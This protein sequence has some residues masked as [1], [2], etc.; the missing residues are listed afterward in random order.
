MNAANQPHVFSLDYE[1][2]LR[3]A[4]VFEDFRTATRQSLARDVEV[5][6]TFQIPVLILA[7]T[8]DRPLS[9]SLRERLKSM[10]LA[11]PR[12][13]RGDLDDMRLFFW[14]GGLRNDP[15]R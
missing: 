3:A 11:L 7:K 1:R 9:N 2:S 5:Y 4:F 10:R 14:L 12:R 15:F 8:Q 6:S 13:Y